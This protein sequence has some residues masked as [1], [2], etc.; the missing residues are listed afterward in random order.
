M[1]DTADIT[2]KNEELEVSLHKDKNCEIRLEV[3]ATAPLV[4]IARKKA[5][6]EVAKEVEVPGFRKGKAPEALIIK[7]H[8]PQ[9]EEQWHR[10][11]AR[12][13]FAALQKLIDIPPLSMHSKVNFNLIKHSLEEG[14]EL[15]YN[16]E[17]E[18]TVPAIDPTQFQLKEIKKAE[19]GQKEIDEA[20]RQIRF[21]QAKWKEI[22]D[23]PI[24]ENDYIIL[25]LESLDTDPAQKVFS[26]TRFE[27]SEK[28]MAT[29]MKKLVLGA[30]LNDVLEGV[31]EPDENASSEEKEKFEKKKVRVTIHKIEEADLPEVNDEFAKTMGTENVEK[32]QESIK[33]MLEQQAEDKV[34]QD[35]REQVNRFFFSHAFDLPLSLIAAEKKTSFRAV[36]K[37][38]TFSSGMA[39][40]SQRR[41]GRL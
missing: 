17:T 26:N 20:I 29:W 12:E 38:F 16:F 18:P 8:G 36:F 2:K 40:S 25:D 27:V 23:R 4:K 9:L 22:T 13:V 11:I 10:E 15:T 35:K 32:L 19:V 33:K 24:Q 37:R 1:A 7:K 41:K 28:G 39:K 14:A 34:D 21:F 30:K 31:S 5:I 3:K 6:K